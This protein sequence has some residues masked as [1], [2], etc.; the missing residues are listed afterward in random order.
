MISQATVRNG[1]DRR[2]TGAELDAICA[3]SRSPALVALIGLA[4][5][6]AM[7]RSELVD[8][9]WADIDLERRV[10]RLQ[11]TKNGDARDVPLTSAAVE[12]FRGLERREDGRVFEMRADSFTQAF[13]RA[14]GK[15]GVDDLRFHDLRRE[16]TSR[17]AEKLQLHE[18][19][20]V[21]G[22]RDMRMVA[23]YYHP[24]AEDL[25]RKLGRPSALG[26]SP[27]YSQVERLEN[28]SV[29]KRGAWKYLCKTRRC[30]G[31]GAS[32]ASL[33]KM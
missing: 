14:C 15:A 2:V 4:V 27:Q 10:V 1:R 11:Q 18:L 29:A 24:R 5:E 26:W 25:A 23:R 16:A 3:A 6:T 20:K 31:Y 12:I 30:G 21:T 9:R 19:A 8:L 22:H 33:E 13:D 17:L 28:Q 7:R 32:L